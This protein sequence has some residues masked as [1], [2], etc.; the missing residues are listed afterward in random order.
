MEQTKADRLFIAMRELDEAETA[1]FD[2]LCASGIECEYF[3]CDSYDGS[4]KLRGSS[5]SMLTDAQQAV[6]FGLGFARVWLH[7]TSGEKY[8]VSLALTSASQ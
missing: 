3:D 2:A 8:Y 7:G 4:I 1:V 6:I 5:L